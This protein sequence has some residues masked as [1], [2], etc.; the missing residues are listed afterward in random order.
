MMQEG[1]FLLE[2]FHFKEINQTDVYKLLKSLDAK[3][4]TVEDKISPKLL[5]LAAE[6]LIAP[7]LALVYFLTK[8]KEQ[9]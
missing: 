7:A 6:S 1:N 5:K 2:T 9:Q 4:L 3:T 8:I